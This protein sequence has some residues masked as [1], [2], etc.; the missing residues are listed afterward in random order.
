EVQGTPLLELRDLAV[1]EAD[2]IGEFP[3]GKAAAGGEFAAE[4]GGEALPELPGVVVEQH[5]ARIV[6]R[7]RVEGSAQFGCGGGVA[8]AAAADAVIGP[9]VDR[10]ERGRG[11]GGED[12]RVVA[13]GGGDVAA[14]VTGEAGADE[15]VGV[16][17]VG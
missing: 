12:A 10:A 5:R 8:C 6:V 13:D 14:V 16:A 11:E 15:V 17:R 4:P 9:V 2:V 3:A 7:R 1:R